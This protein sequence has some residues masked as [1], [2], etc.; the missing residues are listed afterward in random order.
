MTDS[1]RTSSPWPDSNGGRVST[2]LLETSDSNRVSSLVADSQ[3]VHKTA[4][5]L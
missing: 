3:G 1:K 5:R 4:L 2:V